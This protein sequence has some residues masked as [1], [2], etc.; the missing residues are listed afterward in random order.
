M[1]ISYPGILFLVL[2]IS[3]INCNNVFFIYDIVKCII[4]KFRYSEILL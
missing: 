4:V 2:L 1:Q 3:K